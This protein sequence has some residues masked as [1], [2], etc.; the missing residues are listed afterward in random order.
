MKN[1]E[2]STGKKPKITAYIDFRLFFKDLFEYKKKHTPG[3]SFRKL[4]VSLGLASPS[5][6]SEVIKGKKNLS[7]KLILKLSKT[8]SFS[9][10]ECQYFELLVKFNQ[11]KSME[12]KNHFFK[13][14]SKF[15]SSLAKTIHTAQY[16]FYT[17]WYYSAVWSFFGMNNR[18]SDPS[19]IAREIFP[20]ITA[21][22]VKE[23]IKLLL[24]IGLIKKMANGYSVTENHISTE[25]PFRGMVAVEY[26]QNMLDMA[27]SALKTVPAK[28]RQ[29]NTLT[30][31]I[32]EQGFGTIKERIRSFQ[33][34]LREIIE[35][36]Q[37]EDRIYTLSMSLFPNSKK[38]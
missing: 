13:Q 22:Q 3:F 16:K 4:T 5:Y 37:K 28:S 36:D 18:E 35:R 6:I 21:A 32:S 29:Y 26:N 2:K 1:L 17:K 7:Q 38:Q 14:L 25:Y 12:E 8:L 10:L 9:D 34:E 19:K 23:S 20:Q 27:K 24:E 31:S 33:E 11:S 15:R 30:F